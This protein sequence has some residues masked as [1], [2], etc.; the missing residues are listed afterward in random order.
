ME[1]CA[2]RGVDVYAPYG[3]GTTPYC[4]SRHQDTL[5]Y[6]SSNEYLVLV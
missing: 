3:A 4:T 2:L 6:L 1:V 5:M